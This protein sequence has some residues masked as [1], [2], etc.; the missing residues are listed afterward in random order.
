MRNEKQDAFL[1]AVKSKLYS[2]KVKRKIVKI[3]NKSNLDE[4]EKYVLLVVLIREMELKNPIL[5]VAT[6]MTD[7]I[8]AKL[9]RQKQDYEDQRRKD[10]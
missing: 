9:I 4:N 8:M 7:N 10:L 1:K 3:L 5:K 6:K 2:D